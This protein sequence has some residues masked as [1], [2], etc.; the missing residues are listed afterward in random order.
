VSLSVKRGVLS[1][2]DVLDGQQVDGQGQSELSISSSSLTQLNDLLSRVTY[3]STI[4]RVKT[5]DLGNV[6][7]PLS[8]ENGCEL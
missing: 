4:Y 2:E 6:C 5:K 7:C 1:V 8:S 3:T